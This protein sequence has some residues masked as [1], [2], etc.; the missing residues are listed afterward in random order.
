MSGGQSQTSQR[1]LTNIA[2]IIPAFNEMGSIEKTVGGIRSLT[3]MLSE[4]GLHLTIIVIDDGSEDATGRLALSAGADRVIRHRVN[5]GLGAAVR[6]GIRA[7][8]DHGCDILVKFDA[9]LQHDPHDIIAVI[10]PLLKNDADIVY[11]NRFN[12]LEYRMPLIRRAGNMVF[13]WLM[14][15]LT[16]WPILDSQPGI[17]AVNKEYLAVAY[18]P[19]DYNYTQQ[20]LINAYLSKMRFAQ[21]D[22]SFRPRTS[23]TSFISL[24]YPFKVISQILI[25]IA[26][27]R[28]LMIFVPVGI[29][30]LCLGGIVFVWQLSDWLLFGA[31]RPIQNVNLVLGSL[32]FGLQ[33]LCFG[34]LAHLVV[35][36]K[37]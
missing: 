26:S 9:D 10:E 19:G 12:R 14:R 21:V 34:L 30:F 6:T 23:G 25:A 36:I 7:G 29:F 32:L 20:L 16:G 28:P 18:L 8:L 1:S 33:I 35:Q 22:V 31:L 37:R 24:R 5:T 17:F 13:T 11:G 4:R 15:R 3:G 27:V 2:V